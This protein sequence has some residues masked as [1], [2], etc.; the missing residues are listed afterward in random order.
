V[1]P[2]RNRMRRS[3]DYRAAV[4]T[5]RRVG[6]AS[7][8]L[9]LAAEQTS[10]EPARVGFVVSRAVGPA[11][12]RNLVK[13]RLREAVRARITELPP[14]CLAV[15]RANPAAAS[16]SWPVLSGDLNSALDRALDRALATTAGRQ[17]AS[18][19]GSSV[20]SAGSSVSSAGSVQG[21]PAAADGGA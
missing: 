17:A 16:A 1:L 14:G 6:R 5:G 3:A 18:S 11:A 4:R 21:S 8:V 10:T 2:A 12:T 13:R 15:V 7:L 19:A 9:H 20:S